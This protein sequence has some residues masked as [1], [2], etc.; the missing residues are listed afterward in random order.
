MEKLRILVIDDEK[1]FLELIK[2]QL[3]L[4]NYEVLTA[5]NGEDGFTKAISEKPDL[6]ICDINMP[7]KNGYEVLK[8]LKRRPD[9]RSPFIMLT[10]LEDFDKI[11][12]AYEDQAD[13]YVTKPV[14]I[15]NLL[16]NIR[17]LLTISKNKI[18]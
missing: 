8:E 16:K 12:E 5:D 10:I 9:F 13:F 2:E 4:A 15:E 14:K 17:I 3:E 6:V 11:K 18:E 1:D 7:K